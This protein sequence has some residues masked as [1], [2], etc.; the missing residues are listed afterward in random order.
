MYLWVL[1]FDLAGLFIAGGIEGHGD[2]LT[3]AHRIAASELLYRIGLCCSLVGSLSTVLLAVGLYVA[4]KPADENL[5]LTALLFRI[6]EAAV[7]AASIILAFSTLQIQLAAGHPNPFTTEQLS[8]LAGLT[9]GG[10]EI[11]AICF[12]LGSTVFFYVFLKSRYIPRLISVW[13]VF[14]SAIYAL[15]F[16]VGLIVPQYAGTAATYGSGPI[17][18]AE[19]STA[20]WLLIV[21]LRP[22]DTAVTGVEGPLTGSERESKL[23]R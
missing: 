6:V 2:F 14:A 4:V 16:F 19:L 10:A 23:G 8:T 12:S 3:I 17:L 20:L 9:S 7:G 22:V 11:S 5:A 15:V 18:L 21:G 1:A 13:G